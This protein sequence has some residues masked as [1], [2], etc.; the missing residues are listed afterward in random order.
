M[1]KGI[2]AKEEE[3]FNKAFDDRMQAKVDKLGK[4]QKESAGRLEEKV[5]IV[6]FIIF[7]VVGCAGYFC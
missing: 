6:L 4:F 5:R 1:L 7:M 3:A 2:D